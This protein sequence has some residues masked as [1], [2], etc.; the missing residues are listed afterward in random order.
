VRGRRKGKRRTHY[1]GE[2]LWRREE[3]YENVDEALYPTRG[4]ACIN[5]TPHILAFIT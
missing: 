3:G 4:S 1:S 5:L 2:V